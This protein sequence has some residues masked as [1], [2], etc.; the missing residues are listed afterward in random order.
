MGDRILRRRETAQRVGVHR[1]TLRRM[2]AEG[3]FPRPRV[4]TPSVQGW[5]ESVVD[6]WIRT[7]PEVE[8][9]PKVPEGEEVRHG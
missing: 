8:D 4:I 5:P 9:E 3:R 7:R 1:D 6:E 2:V